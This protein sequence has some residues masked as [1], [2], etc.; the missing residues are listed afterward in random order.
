MVVACNNDA[1]IWG[2]SFV[3]VLVKVT[4]LILYCGSDDSGSS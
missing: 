4:L 3:V 1:S 2:I